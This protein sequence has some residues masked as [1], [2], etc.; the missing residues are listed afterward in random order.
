M[1]RTISE[2]GLLAEAQSYDQDLSLSAVST[3]EGGVAGQQQGVMPPPRSSTLATLAE[4]QAQPTLSAASLLSA[5]GGLET[6][7]SVG[8][9]GQLQQQQQRL[10]VYPNPP[11]QP[12]PPLPKAQEAAQLQLPPPHQRNGHSRRIVSDTGIVETLPPPPST[13]SHVHLRRALSDKS[14]GTYTQQSP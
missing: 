5:S 7:G 10:G 3:V 2:R 9:R 8:G 4:H 6:A 14:G 13:P 1:E 11:A 12:P